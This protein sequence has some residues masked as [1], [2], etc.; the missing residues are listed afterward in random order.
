MKIIDTTTFFEEEM[1]MDIRFN[2][3]NQY[4]DYFVVCEALFTHRGDKKK[5][6][7]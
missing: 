3:L 2:I 7:F 6:K 5:N 1:M 4:V